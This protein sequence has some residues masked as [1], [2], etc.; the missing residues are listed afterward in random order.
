MLRIGTGTVLIQDKLLK[1]PS[2]IRRCSVWC[3]TTATQIAGPIF[4]A[5][6]INSKWY[7]SDILQLFFESIKEE[8]KTYGYFLKEGAAAH[9]ANYSIVLKEVSEDKIINFRLWPARFSR[10]L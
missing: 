9:A 3:T 8:E 2:M 7:I 1:Y 6:A 10:P 5:Q 4:F